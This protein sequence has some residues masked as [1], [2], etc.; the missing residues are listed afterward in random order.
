MSVGELPAA[1]ERC[2]ISNQLGM[3]LKLIPAGEFQM[4]SAETAIDRRSGETR[5]SIVLSQAFYLG[6]TEVTQGQWKHVMKTEPWLER[7]YSRAGQEFAATCISWEDANQFCQKLSILEGK[8]YRLPTEA[9]WEYACR[10]NTSTSFSFGNDAT[11][12]PEYGWVGSNSFDIGERYAH[13][14]ARKKPNPWGLHDMHG[15]NWEWC[16][17]LYGIPSAKPASDPK[18]PDIGT[19]RVI[20]GGSWHGLATLCRSASRFKRAP[21]AKL[22]DL[23]FRVVLEDLDPTSSGKT[24]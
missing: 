8:T 10:A 12:M 5:R 11:D 22:N 19:R 9:E 15:N 6:T 17:D 21:E 1:S 23:G 18:G 4:G 16:A 7:V 13:R 24:P 3:K 20:R 14:V 2:L